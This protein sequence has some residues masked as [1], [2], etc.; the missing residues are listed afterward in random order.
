M[1]TKKVKFEIDSSVFNHEIMEDEEENDLDL[2]TIKSSSSKKIKNGLKVFDSEGSEGSDEFNNEDFQVNLSDSC[3][4]DHFDSLNDEFNDKNIPIEPFNLK[5]DREE[6]YFDSEGFYVKKHDQEADQDR[7]MAHVTPSD[8]LKARK[9]HVEN[10]QKREQEKRNRL[11]GFYGKS[12]KELCEELLRET[13]GIGDSSSSILDIIISLKAVK[14]VQQRA[15][16][17]KN[18]LKK[19]QKDQE[20][21]SAQSRLNEKMTPENQAKLERLTEL[22]DLLMDLG[23]FGIYEET[24]EDILNKYQ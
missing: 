5:N 6:G 2:D 4:E 19:L 24:R 13:E 14:N 12:G 3:E 1:T 20:G 8:I 15:P 18:R 22:A 23:H 11:N 17:N 21:S 9:A 16:L 7:W 10:E